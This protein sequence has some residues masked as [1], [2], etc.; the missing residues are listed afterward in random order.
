M[1]NSHI[2]ISNASSH[3]VYVKVSCD[4]EYKKAENIGVDA[5]AGPFG[6]VGVYVN[7][8]RQWISTDK[9]GYTLVT[10]YSS[11]QFHPD[12]KKGT[13]YVTIKFKGNTFL[14]ENH[15]LS[16]NNGLIIDSSCYVHTAKKRSTWTDSDGIDH[17][18]DLQNK[19]FLPKNA[20]SSVIE[21]ESE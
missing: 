8:E 2:F 21:Y 9:A 5:N 13:C 1:G 7:Q 18:P 3:N 19:A 15:P 4:I 10:R 6:G 17:K 11:M 12:S 20:F 14:C 16:V